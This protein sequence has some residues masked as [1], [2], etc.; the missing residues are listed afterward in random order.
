MKQVGMIS[1][2]PSVEDVRELMQHIQSRLPVKE[3]ARTSVLSKSWLRAWSTIPTLRFRVREKKHLK[4]VDR[5]LNRYLRDNIPIERFELD[6]HIWNGECA[7]LTEKWIRSVATNTLKELSLL[8]S[9]H[10][11]SLTLPDEI[12]SVAKNL[13]KLSVRA[14]RGIHSVS[15]KTPIIINCVSLQQFLLRGVRISQ[16][17]LDGIFSSCSLLEN[18][19][20]F[21]FDEDAGRN[22]I[23]IKIKNLARLGEIRICS[24][25]GKSTGLE[26]G[27]VPNLRLFRCDLLSGSRP[28]S[29]YPISLGSSV[30]ELW[31]GGLITDNT[32]LDMIKS[33]FPFL[34]SLSLDLR[35]WTLGN[36]H[37][38]C[39][40]LKKLSLVCPALLR[41]I[42]V[43]VYA[44][45]LLSFLFRGYMLPSFL[46]PVS[47]LN[48]T[49][50]NLD[51]GMPLD[52]SFFLKMREAL[53][54]STKCEVCI[55]ADNF[56]KRTSDIDLDDLR[57]RLPFPPANNVQRLEFQM[58][59]D[60]CRPRSP[61]LD[62]FFEICHPKYVFAK[63]NVAS[64]P[65]INHFF[66][67]M[68]R[69]VLEKKKTTTTKPYWPRYLK[70]VQIGLHQKWEALRNSHRT[71]CLD[72]PI[73]FK[74]NWL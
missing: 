3:A 28:F 27:G 2:P 32:S 16:E 7:S 20:F 9:L 66:Q 4:V 74:L 19:D 46:F 22:P 21:P 36:F 37:F 69:E 58:I 52:A 8:I 6:I 12:L 35:C 24:A 53:T 17:V 5:T 49:T 30:T 55:T 13:S 68:L 45:K 23:T 11:A 48:Q 64:G 51:L 25:Y 62:A 67:V 34:V 26:I 72:V 54:L 50:F 65:P 41:L 61:F 31:L 15:M 63:P 60:E 57:T 39:A 73:H 33:A 18:I 70:H 42:D 29:A 10:G 56:I 40:S 14:S 44:P 59:D 47:T 43:Q 38:T 71:T 1:S